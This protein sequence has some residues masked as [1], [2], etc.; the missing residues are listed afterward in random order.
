VARLPARFLPAAFAAGVLTLV[1]T[2]AR[3][4][5]EK[6]GDAPVATKAIRWVEGFAAGAAEGA[7]SGKVLFVYFGRHHPT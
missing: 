6:P 1:A 3:A 7:K 5:E 2:P 4:D